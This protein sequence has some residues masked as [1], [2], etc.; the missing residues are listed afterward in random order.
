[1][2]NVIASNHCKSRWGSVCERMLV[3]QDLCLCLLQIVA[4]SEKMIRSHEV[5]YF[6]FPSLKPFME[7]SDIK[8]PFSVVVILELCGPNIELCYV[9]LHLSQR[10]LAT[11][12]L[13]L[14]TQP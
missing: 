4:H 10:L 9:C 8:M 3:L 2:Q 13:Q 5:C 6:A 11:H 7:V 1:M 12:V 14:V